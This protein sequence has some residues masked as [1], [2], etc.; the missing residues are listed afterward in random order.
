MQ[1][2]RVEGT[3]LEDALERARGELGEQAIVL[4]RRTVAGGGVRLAVSAA[5][6][7]SPADLARMRRQA[8]TLL[9]DGGAPGPLRTDDVQ[10]SLQ[11]TGASTRL[12]NRVCEAV[13]G[14]LD[15]DTHPLDLAS[16]E[17]GSVF[18]I[19]RCPIEPETTRVLAFL[20][21]PGSGKSTTV[22]KLALRLARAGRRVALATLDTYR[23]GAVEQMRAWG[24]QIGVPVLALR[25][26]EQ[27]VPALATSR[28]PEIV[29]LDTTGRLQRDVAALER[30]QSAL[31][32]RGVKALVERHLILSA[33]SSREECESAA[34]AVT[35]DG[36]VVTKL[37]AT[38][39]P[40]RALEFAVRS[41]LPIAF[42]SDGPDLTRHFHRAS[43]GR[44]ADLMLLGRMS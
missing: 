38:A 37:D 44:F 12:V 11:A 18:P 29:L 3:S 6:P 27:L 30:L 2:Q 35:A 13:A 42:L 25:D 23:V 33:A 21:A 28:A 34:A 5:T 31:A 17:V 39:R 32:R 7:Q 26:V 1:I 24:R 9:A 40:A 43:P 16:E 14:R 22:A 19:A 15:E 8:R 4:S 20:G 10:R 41:R 36:C